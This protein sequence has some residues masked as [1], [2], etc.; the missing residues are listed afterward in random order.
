VEF[1]LNS[2][3]G[4]LL[5]TRVACR[6][7]RRVPKRTPRVECGRRFRQRGNPETRASFVA[8]FRLK[9]TDEPGSFA[10]VD[11]TTSSQVFVGGSRGLESR[12]RP[13]EEA[14]PKWT[15]AGM[16]DCDG[17]QQAAASLR[18]CSAGRTST[19]RFRALGVHLR[20]PTIRTCES[21]EPSS[22]SS[23]GCRVG[24]L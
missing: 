20:V 11:W 7:T 2:G 22:R 16:K 4:R 1:R 14:T 13:A 3:A 17:I 5:R 8:D 9:M 10:G 6:W 24:N 23:C 15:R 21:R 18:R 19:R 12:N